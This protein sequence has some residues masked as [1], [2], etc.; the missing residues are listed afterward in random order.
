MTNCSYYRYEVAVLH[1]QYRESAYPCPCTSQQHSA[2]E[3]VSCFAVAF[4]T[5]AV[6]ADPQYKIA[7]NSPKASLTFCSICPPA[8]IPCGDLSVILC[9]N[10]ILR[11]SRPLASSRNIL[12]HSSQLSPTGARSCPAVPGKGA[13]SDDDASTQPP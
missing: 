3:S 11:P 2:A 8:A 7:N 1:R 5:A 12:S 9:S 4:L 13:T 10:C 6:A